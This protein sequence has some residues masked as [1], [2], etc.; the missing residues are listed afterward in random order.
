MEE[1]SINSA[2]ELHEDILYKRIWLA[3]SDE[4]GRIKDFI[5]K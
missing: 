3:L 4:Y 1:L 5:L 2:E